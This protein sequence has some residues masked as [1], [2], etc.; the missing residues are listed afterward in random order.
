MPEMPRK[1]AFVESSKNIGRMMMCFFEFRGLIEGPKLLIQGINFQITGD[2]AVETCSEI[3]NTF[4]RFL[5]PIFF[6]FL[7]H[8]VLT[9]TNRKRPADLLSA[10]IIGL[11]R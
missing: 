2:K 8:V 10:A 1:S 9:I 6:V 7:R 5:E 11:S 4:Y 3:I